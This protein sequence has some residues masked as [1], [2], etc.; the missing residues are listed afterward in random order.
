MIYGPHQRNIVSVRSNEAAN[1]P[2]TCRLYVLLVLLAM[3]LSLLSVMWFFD[4]NS[5]TL[6]PSSGR[7]ELRSAGS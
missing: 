7:I 5:L 1:P 3:V 4:P 2:S 6:T